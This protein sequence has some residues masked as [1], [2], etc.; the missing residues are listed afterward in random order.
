MLSIS[1]GSVEDIDIILYLVDTSDSIG[2]I[3]KMIIDFLK[4]TDAPIILAIKRFFV[5]SKVS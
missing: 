2:S 5:L 3:E 4:T 1:K